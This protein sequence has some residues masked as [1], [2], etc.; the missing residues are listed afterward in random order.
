MNA[1]FGTF[2]LLRLV[3]QSVGAPSTAAQTP[4][5][6]V[7]AARDRVYAHVDELKARAGSD[8]TVD[9]ATRLNADIEE[10]SDPSERP[11]PYPVAD[12]NERLANVAT[13]DVSFADQLLAGKSE[14]LAGTHGLVERLARSR[15]DGTLQPYALYV[16][17]SAGPHPP[18]VVLLH[19][20]PQTESE[21]LGVPYFRSLADASG[22]VVIAPWGR[23]YYN[24]A[25]PADQD[26][27]A[28]LDDVEAALPV[29][30]HRV[31]LAGYS[32]GGF[33]V[34]K[35]GPLQ[36]QRWRAIMC[37]SGAILNS[38]T[39]TIR[40]RFRDTPFYVVTGAH[41]VN[42]PTIYGEL[43]ASYLM[44]AGIPVSFY[45]QDGGTHYLPTLVPSLRKAWDDM[46]ANV[47][48]EPA[49]LRVAGA[50]PAVPPQ[51][52]AGFKP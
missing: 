43:T 13:L 50:L 51:P 52:A 25:A 37:I 12:W 40:F 1:I 47:V 6:Q 48:R 42:I 46:L 11:A 5:Q 30:S 23:G 26:V 31:Y 9:L 35:V 16:P 38:E 22:A 18:V 33:S 24:F 2:F 3:L 15:V 7:T 27:Y 20:H 14:P 8:L 17:A 28:A 44:N 49:N 21:L 45:E 41:D 39:E 34:F 4:L 29:D 36:A 32:M 10:L 19:G